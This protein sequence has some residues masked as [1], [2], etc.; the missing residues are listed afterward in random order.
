[1]TIEEGE[2][3]KSLSTVA[4]LYRE[5]LG[6]GLERSDL[7]VALGGGMVGDTAGFAAATYMRG[8]QS[9]TVPTTLLAMVDSSIGGKTGVNL[10]EGKNLVGAFKQPSAVLVDPSLLATLPD[11]QLR[12]G[13][14]EVVKASLIADIGLLELLEADG[15]HLAADTWWWSR[16]VQSAASVKAVIVSEDPE[17]RGGR[18][19]LNLGHTFAHSLETASDHAINHGNAVAIGLAAACRLSSRLGLT[20]AKLG[21]R[22]EG[23]LASFGLPVTYTGLAPSTVV[24]AMASDKKRRGGELRFVLPVRLGEVRVIDG[25]P[26][27]EVTAVLAEL[28]A[29]H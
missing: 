10:P 16:V 4:R 1:M 6:S 13:L 27:A 18:L 19:A 21:D 14:S 24:E 29:R 7:V 15:L 12:A 23:L 2:R 8:V 3:A 5:F 20:D 28:R 22:V 11:E 17:E 26:A 9:A 25:V